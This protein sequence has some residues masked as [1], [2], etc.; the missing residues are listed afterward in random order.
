MEAKYEEAKCSP[1]FCCSKGGGGDD[2][3]D[4][5]GEDVGIAFLVIALIAGAGYGAYHLYRVK[6]IGQQSLKNMSRKLW[7]EENDNEMSVLGA[8]TSASADC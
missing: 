3:D 4:N 6:G 7:L 5:T 2:G 8:T 1:E